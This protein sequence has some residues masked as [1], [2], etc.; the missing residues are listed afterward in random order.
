MIDPIP[1]L[2]QGGFRRR[3]MGSHL[4]GR[5]PLHRRGRDST[6]VARA[7]S[8]L[9]RAE[10]LWFRHEPTSPQCDAGSGTKPTP[11]LC[12][13]A[14]VRDVKAQVGAAWCVGTGDLPHWQSAWLSDDSLITIRTALNWGRL[15]SPTSRFIEEPRYSRTHPLWFLLI[16]IVGTVTGS[17]IYAVL[18]LNIVCASIGLLLLL[19][20]D[21]QPLAVGD[22]WAGGGA[23]NTALDW[24][25]RPGGRGCPSCCCHPDDPTDS[26]TTRIVGESLSA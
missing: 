22:C 18:Y 9:G 13:T 14:R 23:G 26:G 24:S 16:T 15:R 12:A 4:H 6:G 19:R 2:C 3:S 20:R 21:I 17:W 5:R 8:G 7:S 1:Y 25:L 10:P 11:G